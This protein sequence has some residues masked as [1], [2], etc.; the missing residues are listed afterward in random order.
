MLVR[1]LALLGGLSVLFAAT[2][3]AEA[4]YELLVSKIESRTLYE[5]SIDS[6]GLITLK[7]YLFDIQ[8]G[9]VDAVDQCL[10]S[11]NVDIQS[12]QAVF[13][14]GKMICVG[15]DQEVLETVPTGT[16]EP[17]GRCNS[18]CSQFTVSADEAITVNVSEPIVLTLQPRAV[19]N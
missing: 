5:Q 13:S 19:T 16:F 2:A 11:V 4:P 12:G 17:F 10:W 9:Q 14:P 6:Q 18:D 15:P 1:K 7:P 3:S 8:A